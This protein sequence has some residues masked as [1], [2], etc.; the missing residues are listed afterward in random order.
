MRTTLTRT[1]QDSGFVLLEIILA[2]ALFASV[3]TAMTVALNKMAEAS[4]SSREEG[5]VLR[6]LESVLAEV[7]HQQ[8][9]TAQSFTFPAD[10]AGVAAQVIVTE[11]D[12]HTMQNQPLDHIFLITADAWVE[13]DSVRRMKRHLESYTYNPRQNK[14]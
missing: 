4:R 12:L 1:R 13:G 3:A 6:K 9:L 11:A 7:A 10:D 5:H 14:I 2:L 8:N